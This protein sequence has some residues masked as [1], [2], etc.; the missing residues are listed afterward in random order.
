VVVKV[1]QRL[2]VSKRAAEESEMERF[3][4]KELRDVEVE[5]ENQVK[6]L[7]RFSA[8][9]IWIRMRCKQRGLGTLL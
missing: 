1:G 8:C 7:N 5:E 6:I 2:S 4:L 3:N 9:E